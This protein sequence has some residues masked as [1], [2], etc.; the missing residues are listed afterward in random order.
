MPSA[1]GVAFYKIG[2]QICIWKQISFSSADALL[3]T[4]YKKE[5]IAH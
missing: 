5:N 2:K 4:F 1:T 3:F